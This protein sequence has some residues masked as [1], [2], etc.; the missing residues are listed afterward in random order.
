MSFRAVPFA[1]PAVISQIDKCK[2]RKN[3][4][5]GRDRNGRGD[6]VLADC[7][8]LLWHG[9]YGGAVSQDIT[10]PAEYLLRCQGYN[11]S[12]KAYP[13]NKETVDSAHHD[14]HHNGDH[15]GRENGP[16]AFDHK[17]GAGNAGQIHTCAAA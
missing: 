4:N 14:T 13:A 10:C 12:R 6:E 2:C 3:Q 9:S 11:K 16:A 15:N 1:H 7:R 8:K 17:E 5:H